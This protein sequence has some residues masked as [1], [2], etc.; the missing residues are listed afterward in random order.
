ME[1][2]E[3][4]IIKAALEGDIIRQEKHPN[5]DELAFKYWLEDS[6]KLLKKITKELMHKKGRQKMIYDIKF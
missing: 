2:K 1:I 6:R 4:E 5:K 3:L